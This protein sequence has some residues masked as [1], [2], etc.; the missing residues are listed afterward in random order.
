[1]NQSLKN[2][3][4][5]ALL[6][7][8]MLLFCV[9]CYWP[10]LRGGFLFDDFGNLDALGALGSVHDWA[11]FC[12][13]ITSGHADPTGRP[14]AL[15]TFL[16]DAQ[17]WP[18]A[19]L[20]FKRTNLLIHLL[21]GMLLWRLLSTLG[22]L[23]R[24]DKNRARKAA[25]AGT[26]LWMLHPL[27]VS[28]TLYI[29]QREAMLAATCTLAGLLAWL[30]GRQIWL[31]SG[32]K[33]EG[34]AWCLVGVVGFTSLGTLA[35]ANGVLLPLLALAI[36]ACFPAAPSSDNLGTL[37]AY[38]RLLLFIA[39]VPSGL[40]VGYLLWTGARGIIA[41]NVISGRSWTL[42]QR[43]LSEPRVLM[44]YLRLLWLPR[45]LSSGLFNDQYV[46]S[47][48][49]LHPPSTLLALVALLSLLSAAWLLRRRHP[50]LTLAITFFFAG[51]LLESTSIP[52]ELYYEHRNY[53]PALLMFWPLAW[54]LADNR[55]LAGIKLV[56]LISLPLGLAW[57]TYLRATEWGQ[58]DAQALL[59]ARIS[60][61]SPRAQAYA[62]SI[63]ISKGFY[64][65][66]IRRLERTIANHPDDPQL[67]FTLVD[68]YCAI[69]TVPTQVIAHAAS[70]VHN[71][72]LRG[73][74][75]ATWL[76]QALDLAKSGKCR[77]LG[78]EDVQRMADLGLANPALQAPGTRQDFAFVR[79]QAELAQG[80][81]SLALNEFK[82]ALDIQVR[83]ELA[84]RAA[85]A[86]GSSG[87]PQLGLNMLDYYLSVSSKAVV[88]DPGMPHLHAWVL[89]RQNYWPKELTRL[90]NQLLAD[91]MTRHASP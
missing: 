16:F 76:D 46:A 23:A 13:Y 42:A 41:G 44:D 71:S 78:L 87:Y 37:P 2:S 85:A 67:A 8:L 24:Q 1:M 17:D 63:E 84:L 59:W 38:R 21:N 4:T 86:L 73:S 6:A 54:W 83:P 58:P 28:T 90:R 27:F 3:V 34:I 66:A 19:P 80:Q 35:K 11:S 40:L 68:A 91:A 36:E 20:P 9:I 77:G 10:G 61:Q 60:P 56:L 31:R 79:A 26:A 64:L 55:I 14:L 25:L 22:Q 70:S 32:R 39:G 29:V 18:A 45:P 62:A 81:A 82:H 89:A 7:G 30:H 43:L 65:P 47:T 15:L 53:L 74:L 52:L 5:I 69:G 72:V 50:A 12:R 48:S 51:Q 57:M 49:L 88:A 75:Y 33:F